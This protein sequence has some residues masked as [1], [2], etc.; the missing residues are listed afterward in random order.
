M[1][2]PPSPPLTVGMLVFP[3]VT[4][5]DLVGPLEVF[6]RIPGTRISLLGATMGAIAS[7]VGL[8]FHPDATLATRRRF[9]LLFV[10][11]GP[12]QTSL[13]EDEAVLGFLRAKARSARFV[14]SVCTGSL[15]LAAAGLLDG[16]RATTH[17]LAL[18]LLAR[19]GARATAE[20]VVV[21]RDRIT[22][23]GVS[24]GLDLALVVTAALAGEAAAREIQLVLEYDPQPPFASGS[25]KTADAAL[26]AEVRAG[27]AELQDQRREQVERIAARRAAAE[28]QA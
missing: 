17:W 5:L 19:L 2:S 9:D 12:G 28:A 8:R 23:A 25:P 20:R 26:V 21:D 1:S 18:D 11:G 3:G 16:Y 22:G 13:M 10:P 14:T 27:R 6:G 15:V 24:A 7:D 4:L